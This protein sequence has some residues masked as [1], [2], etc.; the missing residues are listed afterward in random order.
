MSAPTPSRARASDRLAEAARARLQATP[1]RR[2]IKLTPLA[3]CV[4]RVTAGAERSRA[5][6]GSSYISPRRS[7]A[8]V[9]A[10]TRS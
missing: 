8:A 3:D 5:R 7:A 2:V 10:E 4:A 9:V 6:G 1:T